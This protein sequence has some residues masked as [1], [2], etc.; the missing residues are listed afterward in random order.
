MFVLEVSVLFYKQDTGYIHKF[1]RG[2]WYPLV[3]IRMPSIEEC[4]KVTHNSRIIASR[5]LK[6]EQDPEWEYL[7][8]SEKDFVDSPEGAHVICS[9]L[10]T[11]YKISDNCTQYWNGGDW[12]KSN[13]EITIGEDGSVS[14]TSPSLVLAARR[15]IKK[16]KPNAKVKTYTET[17]KMFQWRYSKGTKK[18]FI[19]FPPDAEIIK[20]GVTP[21]KKENGVLLYWEPSAG[22]EKISVYF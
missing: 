9:N 2:V 12:V 8:G 1:M 14:S 5:S 7:K 21:Y 13:Y 15:E 3:F 11:H 20:G 22:W 16:T 10:V 6:E 19:G 18:D 4:I 17:N